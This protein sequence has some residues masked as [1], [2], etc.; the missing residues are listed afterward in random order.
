LAFPSKVARSTTPFWQKARGKDGT[1]RKIYDARTALTM[2]SQGVTE[3]ATVHVKDLEGLGF[4][5]V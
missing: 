2:T 3:F 4:R 5:K 1:F